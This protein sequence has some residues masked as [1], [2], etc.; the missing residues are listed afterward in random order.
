MK[1]VLINPSGSSV[2]GK[3]I[4]LP[5]PPMG[6]LYIAASLERH[7]KVDVYDYD[8]DI[9]NDLK[10]ENI[11]KNEHPDLIALTANTVT[12]NSARSIATI[13]KKIDDIPI[14][15][16]GLH[17]TMMPEE[18]MKHQDFDFL[19][20]GEA[21]NSILKLADNL[22]SGKSLDDIEGLWY[23]ENGNIKI[24]QELK[25]I[26]NLDELPF[27]ARHLIKNK[28]AYTPVDARA[29]PVTPIMTSR[30]C[31]AQCTFCCTK[32]I[33]GFQFRF[34]SPQNIIAEVEHC[35]EKYGVKEIHVADD[36][37]TFNKKRVLEFRDLLKERNIDV[38]F[39]FLNGVRADQIDRDILQA[40]KDMRVTTIGF[41]CESGSQ[42]ILDNIRKGLKVE[43]TKNAYKLAKEFGFQTWAFFILG[44]P[45]ETKETIKETIK[46]AKEID[47][48]FPKFHILKPYPGSAIF[49][50]LM[51][52]N[53]IDDFDYEKYGIH[54]QPVHHL[55]TLSSQEILDAQ[56]Q[57][58]REFYLRPS[59]IIK[60]AARIRSLTQLKLNM[61][62]ASFVLHQ[63]VRNE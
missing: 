41:G 23:R 19:I 50:E 60:H 18:C 58:Y 31:P 51:Q 1:V 29:L 22:E 56:K 52:K 62:A 13:A 43:T 57:A 10:L 6:M 27:P 53:L 30:G 47:P 61:K 17:A 12:L 38:N 28:D 15:L 20:K 34:R 36:V 55:E 46:F 7:H 54:T 32:Y 40:L 42:K 48:D 2:Y 8:V 35:I 16:G 59:K 9:E 63:M 39:H 33:L 49:N 14:V 26:Q 37:F 21:E 45:G 44:L 25:F 24:N 3:K 11:I 5:Y 4:A